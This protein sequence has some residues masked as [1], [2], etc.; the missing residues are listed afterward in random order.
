M[1]EA[2]RMKRMA[3]REQRMKA[4]T[5]ATSATS[6]NARLSP[7]MG[8]LPL[9]RPLEDAGCLAPLSKQRNP[10]SPKLAPSRLL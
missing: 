8:L 3:W 7:K 10:K 6:T 5:S 2:S 9:K 1:R 4:A